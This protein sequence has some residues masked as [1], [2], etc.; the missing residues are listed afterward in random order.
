MKGKTVTSMRDVFGWFK[1]DFIVIDEEVDPI[2]EIAGIQKALDGTYALMFNNIKGYPRVRCIGN[3]LA[4]T[5][6]LAKMFGVED[7]R[8]LKFKCLDA[9]KHPI[10]PQVVESAPCQEAVITNNIDLMGMLPVLKHSTRDG[11]RVLSSGV[12]LVSGEYFRDGMCVSFK[13]T[14]FRGKDW[15][16]VWVSPGSHLEKIATTE[17]RGKNVPLTANICSPPAVNMIAGSHTLH[18]VVPLGANEIAIAG[19]LQGVPVD[20]V[21]AKTV[22]AYAIANSEIVLEGY[23]NSKDKV[24]ETDEAEK[25]G[26]VEKRGMAPPFLPEWGGYLGRAMKVFKF[27]ITAVTHRLS[28]PILQSILGRSLEL[29]TLT[30]PFR[31][32]CFYEVAEQL[33][34]GLVQ[35]V[36][37]LPG[38][39]AS[40]GNLVF[41]VKKRRPRD[42]GIQ[43]DLT[44]AFSAL[45]PMLQ[46]II[47]VDD[48][49]DI[50]SVD[51]L[52]WAITTRCDTETGIIRFPIRSS[53]LLGAYPSNAGI[54]I[55]ATVAWEN[56]DFFERAHY[57]SDTVDLRK[58]IPEEKIAGARALQ[59]EYAKILAK[60]GH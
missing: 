46:M 17:L 29:D 58:W 8:K 10:P 4:R 6:R 49:V 22:D 27:Q 59:S 2:Y 33:A 25:T 26:K 35:D 34:P 21:K 60:T 43:R 54:G 24:W 39:A 14:H 13:R 7:D 32:A 36:H 12:Y 40:Q 55:D 50:Y 48:D 51:D 20:I 16:S 28:R 1:E 37:I 52:L 30:A 57:P 56:R 47:A 11:A 23:I 31:E 18:T 19:G 42:E 45:S 5:D 41:Q 3:V 38:I 53:A 9:I 15:A 44:A